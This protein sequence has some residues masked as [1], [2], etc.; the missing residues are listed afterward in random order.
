MQ[1]IKADSRKTFHKIIKMIKKNPH[2]GMDRF[3]QVYG[4]FI[5]ITAKNQGCQDAEADIVVNSVLIKIWNRINNLGDLGDI[6]NPEGWIYTV[7]KNCAKDE[8][9]IVWNLELNENICKAEDC[10]E[11]ILER[12]SFEY[13]I[14]CL[15]RE[16]QDIVSM[17]ILTGS[18][19]REIAETFEQPLPTVTST[20][21]RALEKVEKFE[22]N[23][24]FE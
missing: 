24:N 8:L 16:E 22:K 5:F 1:R 20:Y 23:K 4:K 13:S 18:S 14:S 7:A 12:D 19:F 17:K 6:K 21:Y 3:Y 10:Y 2:D 15:K 9:N 11:E